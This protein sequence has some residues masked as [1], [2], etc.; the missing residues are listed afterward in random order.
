MA[1]QGTVTERALFKGTAQY[2]QNNWDVVSQVASG[3]RNVSELKKTELPATLQSRSA[4]E[5]ESYLKEQQAKRADLQKRLAELKVSRD[6]FLADKAKQASGHGP[7]SVDQAMRQT[8]RAQASKY[9]FA[10]PT[11]QP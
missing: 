10:F 3:H 4:P 6:A 1:K 5:L 8:I 7:L 11:P 9:Q 2:S